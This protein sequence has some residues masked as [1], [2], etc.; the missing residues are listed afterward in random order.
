MGLFS[1]IG[2][3]VKKVAAPALGIAASIVPGGT[4]VRAAAQAVTGRAAPRPA[5]PTIAGLPRV[6]SSLA[7]PPPPVPQRTPQGGVVGTL[8]RAI[9]GGRSGYTY[10]RY[11][12]NTPSDKLGRPVAVHPELKERISCPPGYVGV[13]LDGDGVKDA[14]VL[15]G[16]ARAMGL[17]HSRPK[18]PVSGYE[19]RAVRTAKA[20]KS[21]VARL[22]RSTGLHVSSSRP[23]RGGRKK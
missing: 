21:R 23:E 7:A 3:L 22:A 9:P 10:D 14:C 16:V 11:D 17:F 18:P 6:S 4:L 15:K 5:L 12:L 19:A 2:R 1:G 8:R 20:V 13:D